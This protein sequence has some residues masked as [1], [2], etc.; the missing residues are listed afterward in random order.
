VNLFA[1]FNLFITL[2]VSPPPAIVVAFSDAIC[3][4]ISSVPFANSGI[5]II[6]RGPFHITVLALLSISL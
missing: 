6:P 5:S 1:I 4:A 2:I 3:V